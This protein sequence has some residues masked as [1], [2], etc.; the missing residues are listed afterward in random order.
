MSQQ[1]KK[2]IDNE[3]FEMYAFIWEMFSEV[4]DEDPDLAMQRELEEGEK[5]E[6]FILQSGDDGDECFIGRNSFGFRHGLVQE[7]E[8]A[9]DEEQQP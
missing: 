6:A 8:E 9:K 5:E 1:W 3:P 7:E 4:E 2:D